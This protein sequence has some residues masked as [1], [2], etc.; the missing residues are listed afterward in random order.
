[1]EQ[2]TDKRRF[3]YQSQIAELVAKG[4]QL[5]VLYAPE[6]MMA[7]RFAFS[8]DRHNNHIPQYMSNP[9]RMLQ[10]LNRGKASTSLL[11]LSCFDGNIKAESFYQN[12]C[13]AFRNAPS[14]I[15]DSLA[16]GNLSN[17]D[18]LKTET[19]AN[20]HFDFYEYEGCDLNKTFQLTKRLYKNEED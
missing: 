18:G 10:D 19:A 15:G 16:E 11:S 5:P 8:R 2:Y 4:Y 6:N 3:K 1:M 9:K 13:K 17:D 20:G 7:Y 14:S 12:L